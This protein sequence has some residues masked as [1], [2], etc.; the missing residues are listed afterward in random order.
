[1]H[2]SILL[3]LYSFLNMVNTSIE[4]K[5]RGLGVGGR[6]KQAQLTKDSSA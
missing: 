5:K 1:M 2:I 6:R 3:R 4:R